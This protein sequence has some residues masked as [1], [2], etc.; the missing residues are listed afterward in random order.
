MTCD[1][2]ELLNFC[3]SRL[4]HFKTPT[5]DSFRQGFPKGPSGK[6]Q[7]LKLQRDSGAMSA[8]GPM[9]DQAEPD[10]GQ[11]SEADPL[12]AATPIEQIIAE[13]WAKT[14]ARPQI[15][16]EQFSRWAVIR[17]WPFNAC[18][19]CARNCRLSFRCR[20]SSRT[21]QSRQQAAIDP[22]RLQSPSDAMRLPPRPILRDRRL[23]KSLAAANGAVPR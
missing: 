15:E 17:C 8:S 16:P 2:R 5:R 9:S 14:L 18:R 19:S 12:A 13:I 7:R 6:V 4:G 21:R 3:E 10:D 22:Q 11:A 1:E 23:G 20:I